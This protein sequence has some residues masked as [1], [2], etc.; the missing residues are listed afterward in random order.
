MSSD[1]DAE[2]DENFDMFPWPVHEE[3]AETLK[4][5]DSLKE[6]RA[7]KKS[8]SKKRDQLKEQL[9]NVNKMISS[10]T[11]LFTADLKTVKDL[12]PI[13][14]GVVEKR[15]K[16][17]FPSRK[18]FPPFVTD[19]NGIQPPVLSTKPGLLSNSVKYDTLLQFFYGLKRKN[20]SDNEKQQL[21]V[22]LA[23]EVQRAVL[24]DLFTRKVDNDVQ[25]KQSNDEARIA[26]LKGEIVALEEEQKAVS[27]LN[28]EEV[29]HIYKNVISDFTQTEWNRIADYIHS[30]DGESCYYEWRYSLSQ[31]SK[32]NW[33][34]EELDRLKQ[35]VEQNGKSNWAKTASDLGTER[36]AR[37]CYTQWIS[38]FEPLQDG[39]FDERQEN[40]AR[41]VMAVIRE[42]SVYAASFVDDISLT[43]FISKYTEALDPAFLQPKWTDE[44][45]MLLQ[46]AIEVRKTIYKDADSNLW[47]F[48]ADFVPG[49]SQ[50]KCKNKFLMLGSSSATINQ[51]EATKLFQIVDNYKATGVLPEGIS[52][53]DGWNKKNVPWTEIAK[54][55]PGKVPM[56]LKVKYNN[57]QLSK[58]RKK[59]KT[60]R[61]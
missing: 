3:D 48:V 15:I 34:Q 14:W 4:L 39:D 53:P 43:K 32:A 20:W 27:C 35:V 25:I 24:N 38:N 23:K 26:Q 56:A 59:Q 37:S 33:T 8:L 50:M 30:R 2:I 19:Q 60:K 49:K 7:L 36:S 54:L 41:K 61:K 1:S 45:V 17:Q 28:P 6:N 21:V 10:I 47:S 29:A 58:R 22:V 16:S 55:F 44:D 42:P 18:F 11:K 13:K 40:I 31:D 51:E 5:L 57:D 9:I 46:A 52:V 12:E